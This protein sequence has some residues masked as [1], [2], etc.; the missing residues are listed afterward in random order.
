MARRSS[1]N[2]DGFNFDWGAI[3]S[4]WRKGRVH[5]SYNANQYR[6]DSCGA[7]MRRDAYGTTGTYGWEID[8]ARPVS[9]GGSDHLTNL[10][11]LHWR[12]NRGKSDSYPNWSC[13][14]RL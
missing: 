4:V 1:T 3:E 7:L 2:V 5:P 11:P 9:L 13:T 6:L 10:Q 14:V 8:H 12:N